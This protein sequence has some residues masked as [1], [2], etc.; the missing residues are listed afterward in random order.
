[1]IAAAMIALL[2]YSSTRAYRMSFTHD[3]ALSFF[4]INGD[5]YLP[6]TANHHILN[7]F[8][9][10]IC[11]SAFGNSEF[12]LRIPNIL[13]HLLWM[14]SCVLILRRLGSVTAIAAGFLMLNL[15]PFVL[16]FFSLARGYGL[17]L[18]FLAANLY[19]LI[20]WAED[21]SRIARWLGYFWGAAAVL[22]N[23]TMLNYYLAFIAAD[24]LILAYRDGKFEW[25]FPGPASVI[26]NGLIAAFNIGL[27]KYSLPIIFRLRR[28]G[29]LYYGGKEFWSGALETLI[30]DSLYFQDYGNMTIAWIAAIS[31]SG[32]YLGIVLS[33]YR[34]KKIKQFNALTIIVLLLIL[35][36]LAPIAQHL[37]FGTLY[38]KSRTA[39]LYFPLAVLT[40]I[41]SCNELMTWLKSF[42]R[43]CILS[44]M[45]IFGIAMTLHFA[46]TANL[47]HTHTWL[48]DA[49]TK[50]MVLKLSDEYRKHQ[51][52]T[53][54]IGITLIFRP[55]I[56]YYRMIYGFDWLESADR[57]GVGSKKYRYY[58]C[59]PEEIR[60][61]RVKT[62]LIHYYSDTKTVFL[63]QDVG[64][65]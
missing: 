43:Y 42:G 14:I 15:N 29:E 41:F 5:D 4:I 57:D 6:K 1:M 58:Y 21:R 55:A 56:N 49:N 36:L 10:K 59:Y 38:P 25:S 7:S 8:L 31:L 12:S 13:A 9:M 54:N 61:I 37:I 52:K 26:E 2:A 18:A 34:L 17:S 33:A 44:L 40:V 65:E 64:I 3:E 19:C 35:T 46:N 48:Y 60:D 27:L 30:K 28:G 50:D 23:F 22:S 62:R 20:R 45:L 53:V 47:T 32:L 39:L 63:N 51:D 16:D 11:A 24:I